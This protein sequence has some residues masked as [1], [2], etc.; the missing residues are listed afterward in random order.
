MTAAA[1]YDLSAYEP[2]A[3]AVDLADAR[4]TGTCSASPVGH[5]PG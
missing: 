5:V 1:P 3:V 2:S 4:A